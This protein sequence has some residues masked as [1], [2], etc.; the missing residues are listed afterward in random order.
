MKIELVAVV[1]DT[2]FME[3]TIRA[4]EKSLRHAWGFSEA[5]IICPRK[6]AE[7]GPKHPFACVLAE[8]DYQNYSQFMLQ[9]LHKYVEHDYVMTIQ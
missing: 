7:E 5:K 4:M 8:F 6:V 3:G 1:A 2:E 9:E